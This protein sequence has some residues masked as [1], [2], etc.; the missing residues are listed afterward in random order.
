[1]LD[2]LSVV[3]GTDAQLIS[4]ATVKSVLEHFQMPVTQ[5][6]NDKYLGLLDDNQL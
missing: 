4:V 1:M 2:L 5:L 6:S 3:T